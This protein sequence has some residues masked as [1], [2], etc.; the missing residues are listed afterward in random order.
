MSE[1]F[2]ESVESK[3]RRTSP[4]VVAV[5]ILLAVGMPF[6]ARPVTAGTLDPNVVGFAASPPFINLAMTTTI[7]AEI[8]SSYGAGLDDYR[9]TVTAPG[10]GTA[11]AWYNFTAIGSLSVIYGDS[12]SGFNASVGLVGGARLSAGR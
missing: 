5:L 2:G 6:L 9:A 11:T 7:T 4:G 10:G 3:R 1:R 12:T 8:G